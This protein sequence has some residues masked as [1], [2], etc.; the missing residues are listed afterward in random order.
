MRLRAD[1]R[2]VIPW[3]MGNEEARA[4]LA[5]IDDLTTQTNRVVPVLDAEPPVF[6]PYDRPTTTEDSTMHASGT[7]KGEWK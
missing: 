6:T 3:D 7:T 2:N 1:G 4:L 5:L